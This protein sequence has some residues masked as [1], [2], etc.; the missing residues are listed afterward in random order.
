VQATGVPPKGSM[1]SLSKRIRRVVF[2]LSLLP[3]AAYADNK[4]VVAIHGFDKMSC[5]DWLSSDGN[6][7]VRAIYV[8]WIRGIVTGY[9]FANPDDQVAL[10][11]MPGDFSLGLFVD[12][13]CRRHRGSTFAGAAFAL[14]EERRGNSALSELTPS[15]AANDSDAFQIWLKRQSADMRSLDIDILRNIYKKEMALES[16]K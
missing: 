7:D 9:N 13:Y 14:I 8:A 4:A 11:R 15:K 1:D 3:F 2:M 10:G 6:E 16:D 5:N 12:S